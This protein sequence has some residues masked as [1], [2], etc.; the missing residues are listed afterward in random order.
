[1]KYREKDENERVFP[2]P[3]RHRKEVE[4]LLCRIVNLSAKGWSVSD[5][6][7]IT[8]LG[9]L[10]KA[11]SPGDDGGVIMTFDKKWVPSEDTKTTGTWSQETVIQTTIE[12][13][14]TPSFST[15]ILKQRV[16]VSFL[17]LTVVDDRWL[18][19]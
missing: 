4:I 18:G 13:K 6:E 10:G 14:N 3:P 12:L 9:G 7:T 1:M 8:H 2:E 5:S 19:M 11:A 17:C 16:S 15:S